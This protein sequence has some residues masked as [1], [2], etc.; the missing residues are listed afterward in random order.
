MI[1]TTT[2]IE[3]IEPTNRQGR[4]NDLCT[5]QRVHNGRRRHPRK[6]LTHFMIWAPPNV[7]FRVLSMTEG[8][9]GLHMISLVKSEIVLKVAGSSRFFQTINQRTLAA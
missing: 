4:H 7:L 8:N 2:P 9:E 6:S 5:V 3:I 1:R